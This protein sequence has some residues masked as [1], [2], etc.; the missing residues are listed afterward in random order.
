M[1]V[2][3]APRG[4]IMFV[5]PM[6]LSMSLRCHFGK[7]GFPLAHMSSN[8][9]VCEKGNLSCAIL[10]HHYH[11]KIEV[12]EWSKQRSN[13]VIE[14]IKV[15]HHSWFR[16]CHDI[17]YSSCVHQCCIICIHLWHHPC[18][19]FLHLCSTFHPNEK[20]GPALRKDA[21][22][23]DTGSQGQQGKTAEFSHGWM[24][25]GF[26]ETEMSRIIQNIYI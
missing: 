12:L 5:W 11:S 22:A 10:L 4:L 18:I 25:E 13:D 6:D 14:K 19:T 26:M 8:T 20:A 24:D 21:T 17:W 1:I 23:Y 16:S 2:W 3:H 15:Q 7:G 9:I